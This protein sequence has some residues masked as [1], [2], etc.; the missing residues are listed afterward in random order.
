MRLLAGANVAAS[1][2]GRRDARLVARRR[3]AR[4]WPSTLEGLRRPEALARV[5]PGDDAASDAAAVSA[6]RRALA[7]PALDARPRR[8]PRRRHGPRQDDPG[9]RAAARADAAASTT[10]NDRHRA[11]WSRRRRCSPTGRGDR[12][13]RAR[14]CGRW[15]RIP[16]RCRPPSCSALDAERLADVD[17][18]ITSYGSL[19]RIAVARDDARGTWS[20]ST[21]RRRSRIPA[22]KQT[23][24]AK[25]LD[26]RARIALTGTPV[27][28]RLG[29][30]WSI[31][32]FINPGL[33]GSAQGVR[34]AS[35]SGSPTRPHNPYAPL[36]E[37]VRPY[38]LRRLKTDKTVIADLPDKTEVKAYCQLDAQ[39]G[40]A[41]PAGGDGARARSCERAE[42]IKRRG[43]VLAFLMRFK[44]ICNHPSQWLGDGAWA[45]DGQRQARAPARARRGDRREAGEGA[46]LHPVPRDD[47][48]AGRVPR[49]GLRPARARAARRDRR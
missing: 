48:A 21:R 39:A 18:V 20:C 11:C 35:P 46:G 31:F 42:G 40:G 41:L 17:L 34:R 37:L 26:A 24:A 2:R 30:L 9:A 14:A 27:E 38:I 43:V 36:R 3:R 5:D 32:D 8:L 47:R 4:G 1:A 19:L 10:A 44:Q 22:R 45:E 33:L 15:S 29:D 13:L 12:A 23:R 28:N 25:K 16:R 6:G 7:A 49:R